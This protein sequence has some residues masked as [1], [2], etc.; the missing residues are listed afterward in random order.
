[1]MPAALIYALVDDDRRA[2]LNRVH[3]TRRADRDQS[4]RVGRSRSRAGRALPTSA[5]ETS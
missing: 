3:A 4:S 5:E 1:M 2:A